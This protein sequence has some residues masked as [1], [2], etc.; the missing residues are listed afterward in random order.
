MKI[1]MAPIEMI[2]WFD[3][4]GTPRP[5][6]FRHDGNIVKVEMI[7]KISEEGPVIKQT[8]IYDCQSEIHGQMRQF[9]L[10]YELST[11]RWFLW[12]M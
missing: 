8:K 1:L 10:K 2:A 11:C 4:P 9:Q 6:R 12:K 5:I 3:I 7:T